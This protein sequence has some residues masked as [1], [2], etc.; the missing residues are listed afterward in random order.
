MEVGCFDRIKPY[1]Y[2]ST[3]RLVRVCVFL[4]SLAFCCLS[5]R[6]KEEGEGRGRTKCVEWA[7]YR[8]E[9]DMGGVGGRGNVMI[10]YCIHFFQLKF[11]EHFL[12]CRW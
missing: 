3:I 9:E 10:V 12:I 7:G 8:S 2:M 1:S 4:I 6:N 11:V 5:F